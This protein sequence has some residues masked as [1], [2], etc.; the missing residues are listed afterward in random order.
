MLIWFF[1]LLRRK[2]LLGIWYSISTIYIR[3][4]TQNEL[5]IL[6]GFL[7]KYIYILFFI[8]G[9]KLGIFP[10]RHLIAQI[11]IMPLVCMTLTLDRIL[12]IDRL[13][14]DLPLF[15]LFSAILHEYN[16]VIVRSMRLRRNTLLRALSFR[17]ILNLV[18]V[19]SLGE[20]SFLFFFQ[21]VQPWEVSL[22]CLQN[23]SI[24]TGRELLVFLPKLAL[25]IRIH[26][27]HVVFILHHFL[28]Q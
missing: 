19:W 28:I 8:N 9:R 16:S 11:N 24:L 18:L 4:W 7:V 21:I 10:I 12:P 6:W 26:L 5:L 27:R 3:L 14:S 25:H 22:H 17:P 13:V 2:Y 15:I 20:Y 1:T 23:F